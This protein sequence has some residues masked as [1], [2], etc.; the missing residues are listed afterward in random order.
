[1]KHNTW[2][3]LESA[4]L[5]TLED[6][7]MMSAAPVGSVSLDTAGVLTVNSDPSRSNNVFV[8]F[9]K[10]G[11]QIQVHS[12]Q[13]ASSFQIGKVK[14]IVVNGTKYNDYL[15]IDPRISIPS[16]IHSEDG[17]DTIHSSGGNDNTIVTGNGNDLVFG[18]GYTEL[19]QVGDGNSTV[20]GGPGD[21]TIKTGNGND[22]IMDLRGN[23]FI[24]LGNGADSVLTGQ[25]NDSIQAGSGNDSINGSAGN[26]C[27]VGGSGVDTIYV[28]SGHKTLVGIT[29]KDKIVSGP[30]GGG[31]TTTGTGGTGTGGT[32]TGGTGTG[33]TGTTGTGGTGTTGTGGTG[34]GGTGTGGTGTGG[35]GTGG[36]G[37][38]GTGGTGT[39]GTGT[40][41]TG[42]GG[43]GTGGT[44]TGGGG[45]GAVITGGG[46]IITV[47]PNATAPNPVIN[48]LAGTRQTGM[49]VAV[50]ALS[51]TLNSGTDLTAKYQWDFGDVGSKYN[52]LV[53]FNAAHVYDTPGDYTI[54]LTVTNDAGGQASVTQQVTIAASTR[55]QI[56][57]DPINGNDSNP[58]TQSAPIKTLDQGVSMLTNNTEL[59]LLA[60]Q[61]YDV[62]QSEHITKSN[63]LI[64]RWGTGAD[65]ILN[66]IQG[67]GVSTFWLGYMDGVTIQNI[68][69]DS[70][71]AVT[72]NAAPNIGVSAIFA[73][74]KNVT[75][76][77]CTF[78]NVDDAINES[79]SPT[80]VLIQDNTSPLA[81]GLRGYFVWTVGSEQT[82]IGNYAANSTRQHIV[83]MVDADTVTV[84]YNDFTNL[85]RSAVDHDDIPKG[86]IEVHRAANIYISQNHVSVGDIRTGPLGLW[87]ESTTTS[88]DNVVVEDNQLTDTMMFV[89]SGSHHIMMRDN[90]ITRADNGPAFSVNSGNG[91]QSEDLTILNNTVVETGQAGH[92]LTLGGHIDGIVMDNN[93]YIAPNMMGGLCSTAPVYVTD[94]DLSSFTDISNNVWTNPTKMAAGVTGINF[95]GKTLATGSYVSPSAW[96]AYTQVHNDTF[97]NAELDA[98]SYTVTIGTQMIGAPLARAA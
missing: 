89:Q 92:F 64:G 38:T 36:T 31:T 66:R 30:Q 16:D 74:G 18:H 24:T 68:T 5:E 80:G 83:R 88:T 25:G 78:L 2:Q 23:N 90:V 10:D 14:K 94:S 70:P 87:G 81:T 4:I 82:I 29:K 84:E 3:L 67:G 1:M 11:K 40:G 42:T 48:T 20:L 85:D 28:G 21:D 63:V 43:T 76:R 46:P 12:D 22:N 32:G 62:T 19:I 39:G 34:T 6:R 15:Y 72:G 9:S 95:I 53:G 52:Q 26:D 8:D 49:V 17:D 58:G 60:G 96:N 55:T 56:F 59:L 37:T 54:T 79:S 33:G 47:N 73:G 69:F 41:G 93:V 71:Y 75:V 44:G 61:K 7:Q 91:Y 57:V 50:D 97:E 27:I 45:S 98:G 77:N 35:T 51:T 65:P 86:C 13:M